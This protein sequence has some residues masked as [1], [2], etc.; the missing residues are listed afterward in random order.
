LHPVTGPENPSL[1][2]AAGKPG[3]LCVEGDGR[4][5]DRYMSRIKSESWSDIP[6]HQKKVSEVVHPFHKRIP[7]SS[8]LVGY[9]S[10][11]LMSR[12][13]FLSRTPYFVRCSSSPRP[14][15]FHI[16][17]RIPHYGQYA[18]RGEMGEVKRLMDQWGVG[19]DFGAVVMNAGT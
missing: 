3:L 7:L 10:S 9:T 18:H 2:H 6:P 5:V 17:D 1:A 12:V 19:E 15:P 4:E 8:L 11:C 14:N 16:T 13:S